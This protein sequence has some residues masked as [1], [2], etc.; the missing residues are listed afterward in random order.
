LQLFSRLAVFS[1]A[2]LPASFFPDSDPCSTPFSKPDGNAATL[3]FNRPALL[4]SATSWTADEDF[5]ILLTALASYE[6][7]A[8]APDATLPNLVVVVTGKGALKSAF[9]ADVARLESGPQGWQRVR[10]RTAWL[11]RADYPRLLGS[12]DLGLSLHASTSGAD[13]PMKVVDCFGCGLPV[14][15]LGFE[16]VDELIKDGV[17]GRVF[18]DAGQLVGQLAGLLVGG[19]GGEGERRRLRRGI[20]AEGTLYAG[21][22]WGDWETHWGRVVRPLL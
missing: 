13:L 17:N 21:E 18:V 10:V 4:V 20:E 19:D 1:R 16:C 11:E 22:R 15:A 14:C 9:E 3:L 6:V 12:A 5:S 2:S 8:L 7:A